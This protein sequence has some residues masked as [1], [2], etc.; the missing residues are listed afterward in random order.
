M[1]LLYDETTGLRNQRANLTS[2]GEADDEDGLEVGHNCCGV[3]K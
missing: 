1:L 2:S 3:S